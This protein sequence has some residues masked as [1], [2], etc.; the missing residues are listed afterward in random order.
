MVGKKDSSGQSGSHYFVLEKR[1]GEIMAQPYPPSP[2]HRAVLTRQLGPRPRC[3]GRHCPPL[4]E[5]HDPR[6]RASIPSEPCVCRR[7]DRDVPTTANWSCGEN[8]R[9]SSPLRNGNQ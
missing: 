1:G 2:P 5:A 9:S 7:R 3:V 6:D 8:A 4:P